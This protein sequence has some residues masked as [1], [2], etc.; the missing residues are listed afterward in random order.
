LGLVSPEEGTDSDAVTLQLGGRQVEFYVVVGAFTVVVAILLGKM[1]G[2]S[3]KLGGITAIG[4]LVLTFLS[5]AVISLYMAR[6]L[7]KFFR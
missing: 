7:F 6:W 1:L 5:T 2:I 3:L 4:A